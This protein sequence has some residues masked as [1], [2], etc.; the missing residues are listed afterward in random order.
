MRIEVQVDSSSFDTLAKIAPREFRAGMSEYVERVG[1]KMEREAKYAMRA[2][3]AG[4]RQARSRTGNLARQIRFIHSRNDA[5]VVKAFANYSSI[6]HGPPFDRRRINKN[7]QM[8]KTNPF[9]TTASDKT[10][11][12]RDKAA[13][14]MLRSVT[15]RLLE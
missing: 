7:G 8:R 6:V 9:F 5:G 1:R 3:Q 2:D 15:K 13:H 12:F 10:N 11:S 14:D 4:P